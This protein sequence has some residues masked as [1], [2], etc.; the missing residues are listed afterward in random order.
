LDSGVYEAVDTDAGLREG[1]YFEYRLHGRETGEMWQLLR[2]ERV[3]LDPAP[4]TS[5]IEGAWPNP[6][7]PRTSIRFTVADAGPASLTIIDVN[8]ALVI[9]LHDGP[10][11]AG[12][13][14]R[15]WDGLDARGVE[16]GS[17]VYFVHLAAAGARGNLKLV[18]IR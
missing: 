6:F 16:V 2:S 3:E 18:L 13:H 17:G 12:E 1:G 7:N 4:L 14:E 15:V 8:G 11:P 10:L 5:R 9:K